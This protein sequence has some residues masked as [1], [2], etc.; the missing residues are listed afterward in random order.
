MIKTHLCSYYSVWT[1]RLTIVNK[2]WLAKMKESKGRKL[3]LSVL[4]GLINSATFLH[5]I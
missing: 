2:H 5:M 4:D 3:N 1:E